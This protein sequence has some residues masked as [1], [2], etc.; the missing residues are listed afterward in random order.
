MFRSLVLSIATTIFCLS[1]YGQTAT[2]ILQ[3]RV[4]DPSGAAIAEATVT[5]ENQRTGVRQV[6]QTNANGN[7]VQTYLIPSEYRVTAEKPGF[8]KYQ[9]N[10][11]RVAVQQTVDLDIPLK[12]GDV[13]TT[14]EVSANAV[15]LS[16][17]TSSVSTVITTKQILELP[18][19]GRGVYAL[20]A[21]TPGVTGGTGLGGSFSGGRGGTNEIMID[22]TSITVP[23]N[24]V[25]TN[26]T[27][28]QPI[29][30]SVEEINVIANA[31]NAE[32]GRTGGG[33]INV[34]SKS[35]TNQFHGS[36]FEFLR[37]DKLNANSW[38]NN[39]NGQRKNPLRRNQFGGTIGGPLSIPGLYDGKNRTFFFFAE[40]STIERNAA[41]GTA[42]VPTAEM[43]AGNFANLRNSAGQPITIYDPATVA[44]SANCDTANPTYT[45][46]P[47][48]NN[49]IP[50]NRFD[51]VAMKM[52][53]YFPLPNNPGGV[54]NQFTQQNNYRN[55]GSSKNDDHKFDAR[56]D[57]NFSDK[58]RLW[59]RGSYG[60]NPATPFNLYDNLGT[61]GDGPNTGINYNIA[62]NGVYTVSPTTIWNFN[63]GLPRKVYHRDP[64][65]QGIDL[66]T[67]GFPAAVNLQAST[68]N[69][70]FPRI[71]IGGNQ[72]G[73][74][75][76]Q[77]TFTALRIQGYDH[78]FRSDLTKVLTRHTIK[79]G[80]QHRKMFLNFRQ[81]GAPSGQYNFNNT[82]WTQQVAN[83]NTTSTTQGLGFANFLLGLPN[84]S[85]Q[86]SSGSGGNTEHT[87]QAAQSSSY[88]GFY[89]QDDWKVTQRL[90]LNIGLRW[91]VD[92]PRTERYDR[93]AYFDMD[94][95]SPLAGKVPGLPN[96]GA[97][98]RGAMKFVGPDGDYGRHQ[99]P[100]DRNNWGPRFGFAY[101][102][103]EKTVFRGAYG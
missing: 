42:T 11:V 56:V 103:G 13:A 35:G 62:L 17:S 28:Y 18:S 34:A 22:G 29:L 85:L 6:L 80:A 60:K 63:Y 40:Q 83:T 23:E 88:W 39:R 70:E 57:H 49:Q 54:L 82:L 14:I 95:P 41:S 45:R 51:P 102:L 5:V 50:T 31:M 26:D 19:Q 21:L 16:T 53:A 47:F 3:G 91:D 7:F 86:G 2:G 84:A 44:C 4:T 61:T 78:E 92:V 33:A 98:L 73:Y 48:P 25:S 38:T 55:Q 37:N 20:T 101:Q 79:G 90:T 96:A 58:F 69:Q 9:T 72:Q 30:D 1:A 15:Q 66:T 81:N 97:G 99:A 76:G 68:Q 87:V 24:N 74:T 77:S 12:V 67:L 32:Y 59:L 36:L 64:F 27:G 8:Q 75:L 93:L 10:D 46:Q 43:R 89:L 65:S 52:L 94:A 71:N 100:T